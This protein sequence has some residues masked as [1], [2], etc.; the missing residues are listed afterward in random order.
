M[1]FTL[2]E[3]EYR[4]FEEEGVGLCKNCG[5]ERE[6]TEPDAENY[7]CETCG[8][9]EV[10]GVGNLLLEGMINIDDSCDTNTPYWKR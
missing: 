1:I 4:N 9:G 10:S 8:S 3:E 6:C 5:S 2:T 7:D